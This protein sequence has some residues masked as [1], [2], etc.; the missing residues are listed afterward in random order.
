MLPAASRR[1]GKPQVSAHLATHSAIADSCPDCLG[2]AAIAEKWAHRAAGSRP[3]NA[4]WDPMGRRLLKGGCSRGG[5]T[6]LLGSTRW[7][8]PYP[9][10][11]PE[12]YFRRVRSV[13]PDPPFHH[14]LL[15]QDSTGQKSDGENAEGNKEPIGRD[16]REGNR[17]AG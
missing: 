2:I 15:A 17:N 9:G 12:A 4:S 16:Q 11:K 13:A 1:F 10:N 5:P 7:L 3:A 14:L 6:G 8:S